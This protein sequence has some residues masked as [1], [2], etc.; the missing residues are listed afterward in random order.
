MMKI[1]NYNAVKSTQ[2]LAKKYLEKN[3]TIAAFVANNQTAGYG[4]QGRYFYSPANTGIY[5][6]LAI[7]G[8]IPNKEKIGLLTPDIA[9]KVVEVLQAD[10]P[11][12]DF[13]LKWVNDIYVNGKKIA[14]ILTEIQTNGLVIGLGV[15]INTTFF[16][17]DLNKRA[18]SISS[19]IYNKQKITSKIIAV[20]LLATRDYNEGVFLEKYRK[21]S[22]VLNRQ[23]KLKVG[24][25]LIC[26]TAIEIDDQGKLIVNVDG[27]L[28]SFSSGEIIKLDL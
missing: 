11:N 23:V 27:K 18:G 7:P 4:K 13:K 14:G 28:K 26:G 17:G 15:N 22:I 16:P 24:K 5:L 9:T 10:F 2:D 25:K 1:F 8:F 21:L 3:D 20:I 12:V 6:S 19:S